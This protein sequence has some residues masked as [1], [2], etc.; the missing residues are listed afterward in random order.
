[1]AGYGTRGDV[2]PLLAVALHLS[3]R[4]PTCL[5]THRTHEKWL[6]DDFSLPR[7]LRLAFVEFA[8]SR[9]WDGAEAATC[10]TDN[11]LAT[12]AACQKELDLGQPPAAG[13]LP[14]AARPAKK[15]RPDDTAAA[16][17]SFFVGHTNPIDLPLSTVAS[18]HS[19]PA[20]LSS[21]SPF[22]TDASHAS[23]GE[24]P[25]PPPACLLLCNLFALECFHIAEAYALP[26][27]VLSPC[28]IPYSMP[29][30]FEGRF[31]RAYPHLYAA[32]HAP[33][34]LAG[35]S[36]SEQHSDAGALVDSRAERVEGPHAQQEAAPP[37]RASAHSG[38]DS[39]P[40]G[41]APAPGS[42][43]CVSGVS[44]VSW[45]HVRHWM[46]ALFTERWGFRQQHLGLGPC[47]LLDRQGLAVDH[48]MMARSV[49]FLYGLSEL[50]VSRPGYWPPDVRLCGF[51]HMPPGVERPLPPVVARFLTQADAAADPGADLQHV[52]AAPLCVDFGSMGRL[53]HIQSPAFL[54]AVLVAA[55]RRLQRPLLVLT[56]GWA[57]LQQAFNEL[58]VA[59]GSDGSCHSSSCGSMFLYHGSLA[60]AA[61][62]PRCVALLHHGGAGTTAAAALAGIAQVF[63]PMQFDQFTTADKFEHMGMAPP[64]IPKASITVGSPAD[65]AAVE[66]T[67]GVLAGA[68]RLAV[69][70]GGMR[71]A[72][73]QLS[74]GLQSER[75]AGMKAAM[76]AAAT[77]L[78]PS[79]SSGCASVPDS[80]GHL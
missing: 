11:C 2:Q 38:A 76:E 49:P 74:D 78:E 21:S 79:C 26:L 32:L 29:A 39:V 72:R 22:L 41:A 5:L 18:D 25:A 12:L 80:D 4:W 52:A 44:R 13:V 35:A 43:T 61:L 15:M 54:A 58:G 57:P 20:S 17:T 36:V 46:W 59:A 45:G 48:G 62:L 65:G 37:G 71:A 60:H 8:P 66:A 42:S 70:D 68:L 51:W 19:T 67:A 55:V 64:A 50:L 10:F 27:V 73:Q 23:P 24:C 14:G 7:T 56:G 63:V 9:A 30:G 75:E 33:Q 31:K 34:P 1:M 47:P 40:S 6:R 53:G 28:L 77:A 69:S 3:T 16:H